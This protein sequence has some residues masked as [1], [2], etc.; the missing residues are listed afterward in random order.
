VGLHCWCVVKYVHYS[1]ALEQAGFARVCLSVLQTHDLQT[2]QSTSVQTVVV[3][4]G[5]SRPSLAPR[6]S[7][8]AATAAAAAAAGGAQPA[9]YAQ[10]EKLVLSALRLLVNM[11]ACLTLSV[12]LA[13][14][15]SVCCFF[16]LICFFLILVPRAV[17]ACVS[18]CDATISGVCAENGFKLAVH[19][20]TV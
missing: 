15:V 2:Q 10:H 13:T 19:A 20:A 18:F 9:H 4:S 12:A 1:A 6:S 11:S 14:Q 7:A 3:K 8:K 17:D 5:K 16:V